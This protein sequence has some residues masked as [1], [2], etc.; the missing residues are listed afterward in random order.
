VS[1]NDRQGAQKVWPLL[2]PLNEGKWEP[3]WHPMIL[4]PV[5]GTVQERM[6]LLTHGMKGD[7]GKLVWTV[8]RYDTG[9]H[10][11][12]YTVTSPVRM[13]LVDVRCSD[14]GASLTDATITYSYIGLTDLGNELNERS[15]EERWSAAS[16]QDR[17]NRSGGSP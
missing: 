5:D 4:H 6:V 7:Q 8:T 13:F 9:N 12:T 16:V 3:A 15:S 17:V 11:I 10:H 1:S 14:H 2:D